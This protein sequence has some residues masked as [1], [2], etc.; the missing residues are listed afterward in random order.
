MK[1]TGRTAEKQESIFRN[2][3]TGI[4]KLQIWIILDVD[5]YADDLRFGGHDAA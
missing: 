5:R 3:I 2:K 1:F 4:R